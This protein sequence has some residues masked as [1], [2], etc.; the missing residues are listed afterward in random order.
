MRHPT[1]G[2]RG[3][4]V[5]RDNAPFVMDWCGWADVTKQKRGRWE[6]ATC[7]SKTQER[8]AR[9]NT[10]TC[11]PQAPGRGRG[12]G[13]GRVE[14]LAEGAQQLTLVCWNSRRFTG[15]RWCNNAAG[16]IGP[17]CNLPGRSSLRDTGA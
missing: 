9:M 3:P 8:C 5:R 4:A 17:A 13:R 6:A 1:I 12:R 2:W 10:V 15:A 7:K 14:F 11:Q 16:M